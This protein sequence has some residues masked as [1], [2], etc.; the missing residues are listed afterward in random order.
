MK[1]D[2]LRA[3]YATTDT[4]TTAEFPLSFFIEFK[5]KALGLASQRPKH[6]YSIQ[7]G[8]ILYIKHIRR[9][10]SK[11]DLG[12]PAVLPNHCK[13][14]IDFDRTVMITYYFPGGNM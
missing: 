10:N 2:A 8:Y 13:P 7:M 1:D 4:I 5:G 9:E 11:T 3:R 6:S 14:F 12:F